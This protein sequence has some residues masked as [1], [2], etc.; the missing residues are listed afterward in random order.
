M[1]M[2]CFQPLPLLLPSVLLTTRCANPLLPTPDRHRPVSRPVLCAALG[3]PQSP[4]AVANN[5]FI[6]VQL[7]DVNL[8]DV[9]TQY[10][11][12]ESSLAGEAVAREKAAA[13]AR[14]EAAAA[15]AARKKAQEKLLVSFLGVFLLSLCLLS[16]KFFLTFRIVYLFAKLIN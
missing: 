12:R 9:H 2:I 8:I 7:S 13:E 14:A 16:L 15:I 6:V 5:R 10:S 3:R 4:K 1:M 11:Y